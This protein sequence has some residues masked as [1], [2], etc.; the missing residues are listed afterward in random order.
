MGYRPNFRGQV[1]PVE[2]ANFLRPGDFYK[3]FAAAPYV[4]ESGSRFPA[5]FSQVEM[6]KGLERHAMLLAVERRYV[7]GTSRKDND[8]P[9]SLHLA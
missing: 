7:T 2:V 8:T 3:W 4:S 5:I 9:V 1:I 6:N